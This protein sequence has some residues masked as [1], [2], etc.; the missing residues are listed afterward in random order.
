MVPP[1]ATRFFSLTGTLTV[2]MLKM[3]VLFLKMPYFPTVT[4]DQKNIVVQYPKRQFLTA[5]LE[6]RKYMT[7]VLMNVSSYGLVLMV[8]FV[9]ASTYP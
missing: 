1:A 7:S 2:L 5:T 9:Q 6:R 4:D 8:A 3:F